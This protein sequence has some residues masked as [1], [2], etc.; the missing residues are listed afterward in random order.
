MLGSDDEQRNVISFPKRGLSVNGSK[1]E[2][3]QK[4]RMIVSLVFSLIAEII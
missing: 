4:I 1:K 3:G 2:V